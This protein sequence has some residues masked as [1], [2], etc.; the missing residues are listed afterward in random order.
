MVDMRLPVCEEITLAA[1]GGISHRINVLLKTWRKAP[2]EENGVRRT[3][4]SGKTENI[5]PLK[6][7]SFIHEPVEMSVK[8]TIAE[9]YSMMT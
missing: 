5:G 9:H 3:P 1:T 2:P 6:R 8:L 7:A 4:R